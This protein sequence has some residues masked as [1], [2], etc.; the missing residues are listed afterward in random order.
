MRYSIKPFMSGGLEE[1]RA[2]GMEGITSANVELVCKQTLP[3]NFSLKAQLQIPLQAKV[4]RQQGKREIVRLYSKG[5]HVDLTR[6]VW[7]VPGD[8]GASCDPDGDQVSVEALLIQFRGVEDSFTDRGVVWVYPGEPGVMQVVV[9]SRA[10]KTPGVVTQILQ[11]A[12]KAVQ[13]KLFIHFTA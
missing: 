13:D 3:D 1:F 6:D 10:L 4:L 12:E 8:I 2:Q 7:D 5:R 9:C 11:E